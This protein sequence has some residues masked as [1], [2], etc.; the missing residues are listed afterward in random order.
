MPAIERCGV[1]YVESRVPRHELE[2]WL[3]CTVLS[4]AF[5]SQRLKRAEH[6]ELA[7]HVTTQG[8]AQ[9]RAAAADAAAAADMRAL[10][11]SS[12]FADAAE[13]GTR[14]SREPEVGWGKEG[15]RDAA[16]KGIM[17]AIARR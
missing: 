8:C 12:T 14:Q 10:S 17:G 1:C 4:A 6:R 13:S 3:T 16:A 2:P 15:R 11:N 9:L 5:A 7:L